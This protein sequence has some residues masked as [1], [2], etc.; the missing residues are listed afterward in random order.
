M[1]SSIGFIEPDFRKKKFLPVCSTGKNS[2]SVKFL[3][4]FLMS[5]N[6]NLARVGGCQPQKLLKVIFLE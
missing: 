5:E 2:V 1:K 3:G 4:V 6:Q